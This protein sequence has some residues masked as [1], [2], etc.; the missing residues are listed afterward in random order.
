MARELE[1]LNVG[2]MVSAIGRTVTLNMKAFRNLS[3]ICIPNMW[4]HRMDRFRV[5]GLDAE[6][7]AVNRVRGDGWSGMWPVTMEVQRNSSA[8]LMDVVCGL[9]RR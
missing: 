7:M 2:M 5:C 3:I 6:S 8:S 4:S 9:L 1:E